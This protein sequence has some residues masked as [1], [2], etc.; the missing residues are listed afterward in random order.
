MWFT[1]STLFFTVNWSDPWPF[2]RWPLEWQLVNKYLSQNPWLCGMAF[3]RHR[4]PV[5]ARTPPLTKKMAVPGSRPSPYYVPYLL[6]GA[7]SSLEVLLATWQFR[8][9][10]A[11][12]F[13][14]SKFILHDCFVPLWSTV[15]WT[16][17]LKVTN[18]G[19]IWYLFLSY[20]CVFNTEAWKWQESCLWGTY[21]PSK[22]KTTFIFSVSPSQ[23]VLW[24]LN[25][26]YLKKKP[27]N[28]THWSLS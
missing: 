27:H 16:E 28:I 19:S 2:D 24:R 21:I 15:I 6:F 4:R 18:E 17:E 14:V 26:T 12:F 23:L 3:W 1:L 22:E 8:Q 20:L 13:P 25:S 5:P 10:M 9:A 11:H 7:A